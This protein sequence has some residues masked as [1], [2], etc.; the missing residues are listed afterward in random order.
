LSTDFSAGLTIPTPPAPQ[1][2]ANHDFEQFAA[3]PTEQVS[4][5]ETSLDFAEPAGTD[6]EDAFDA[7]LIGAGPEARTGSSVTAADGWPAR[8]WI[9]LIGFAVVAYLL[10]APARQNRPR[11]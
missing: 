6:F 10:F 9:F 1:P 7:T 11:A 3:T 5:T 2:V 4:R 8:T